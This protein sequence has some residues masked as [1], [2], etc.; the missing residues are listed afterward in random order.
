MVQNHF[1]ATNKNIFQQ[2]H[3][4]LPFSRQGGSE[5]VGYLTDGEPC[6]TPAN[7][8]NSWRGNTVHGALHGISIMYKQGVSRCARISGFT[9]W[10]NFDWGLFFYTKSRV[11]VSHSV[12]AD[13]T[14]SI[15][16]HVYSPHALSHATADKFVH[17]VNTTLIGRTASWDCVVDKLP[18]KGSVVNTLQRAKKSP[19]GL[20]IL[21][22]YKNSAMDTLNS[23]ECTL[24]SADFTPVN[25]SFFC[26]LGSF[27]T[28]FFLYLII[29]RFFK[30]LSQVKI[31]MKY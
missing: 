17:V 21:N 10:K 6:D 26:Y 23:I 19:S 15:N 8:P 24:R 20:A 9:V 5:R 18:P 13:N 2:F 12:F 27:H 4:P 30:R 29:L 22:Y 31:P 14:N 25:L 11:I 28:I 1:A 16:P 3:Q 7:S